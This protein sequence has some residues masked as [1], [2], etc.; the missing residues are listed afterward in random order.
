MRKLFV[1]LGLFVAFSALVSDR[2]LLAGTE[3]VE[4]HSGVPRFTLNDAILTALQRNPDIQRARQEIE[5]TKG[6]FLELR[7][8]AL[9]RIDATGSFNDTDPHL[10][11]FT[12]DGG[13]GAIIDPVTG[14]SFGGGISSVER[15]YNLNIQATQIIFAGGRVVSQIRSA[16][17]QRDSSYFAF[18]DTID[19]V[20]A[21]VRQQFYQ[22][23]LNRALIGVQEESV[24]LLQS[25]LKDQQNRF[26]AGTVPR[27]NVLQ[28]QVALSNQY[29][30]L[31]SARNNYR[32]SQ[33][34]LAKTI[35]LD[36][37]PNRGDGPPLEAVGELH[38]E[39][40]RMSLTRAIEVA[41]QRRPFLKQQKANVLASNAQVG[42]ARSGF[43][44]QVS[45]TGGAAFRSSPISESPNDVRSGYV[46]GATGSW[47][48]WD[49]GQTYGKVK[50]AKA[51]LEQSKITYDDA[52]RQI[53]LEVQQAYSNLV[54]SAE[55]IRSQQENVGQAQEA[56][57]L[58]SA[59]L[60]AG[61]GTQLEVL[62]AR[63]E[64]TRA[65]STTL[66][67]LFAYN[68]A[69]SEFDRVTA[70]EVTYSNQLDEPGTRRKLRTDPAPTPP[71]KPTPLPLNH[72]GVRQRIR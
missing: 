47:A 28:A 33:L 43:F 6:L 65:Q 51:V 72:A 9:P 15:S 38:E 7:A 42:V 41:K 13:S 40:R 19:L 63:V 24:N 26:E 50:Q 59:R 49:W 45:A 68:A 60:G 32:I 64:V 17:F 70:T 23:L 62:N 44:P 3:I 25:Q 48:I 54:Q 37:D 39:P 11:N 22:V 21:T 36:F 61:A 20:I 2:A 46:F 67:A 5:R 34:Q 66:Q 8:D 69:M 29:P 18:R 35:G 12:G 31:I 4:R 1:F 55:L 53:E 71:P 58:A 57:R 30:E 52:V 14:E 56:L 27:F 16:D 10:N